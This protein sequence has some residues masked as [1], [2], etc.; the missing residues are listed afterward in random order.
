MPSLAQSR[1]PQSS[2]GPQQAG[3]GPQQGGAGRSPAPRVSGGG[4][5][6]A[7]AAAQL[8]AAAGPGASVASQLPEGIDL[9]SAGVGFS[10]PGNTAL[11]GNWNQLTT[12]EPTQVSIQVS[13]TSLDLHFWPALVVD[14]Q[15][16]LSNVAWRGLTWDFRSG[17]ISSVNLENTQIG[18]PI[19]G[20]VR[21]EIEKFVNNLMSGTPLQRAGYNPLQDTDLGGTLGKLQG[22]FQASGS[23]APAGDLKPE[24]VRG[25]SANARFAVK[26]E[27]TQGAGPG[28]ITVPAGT[29]LSVTVSLA[30][31]A[32]SLAKG[33]VPDV[34]GISIDSDGVVLKKNGEDVARLHS[35]HIARGGQVDVT[36]FEALGGVAKAEGVEAGLRGLAL[37]LQLA[38]LRSGQ[39]PGQL[40]DPNPSIVSGMAEKEIETALTAAVRQLVL[41][42]HDAV[43]GVDLRKVLGVG[44]AAPLT[45]S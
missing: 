45:D 35:L 7:A 31:D 29:G 16:P 10:L 34:T 33:G 1:S 36:R 24:Q 30:G 8:P 9:S 43:P 23:G 27:I 15:W 25:A 11:T 18:V 14:A 40:A 4:R 26:R 12:T 5:G 42:H 37:L 28:S 17:R 44:A 21:G 41:D 22:R 39:N 6:N 13:A 20:T 3:T 2:T 19:S 32:A 38:A